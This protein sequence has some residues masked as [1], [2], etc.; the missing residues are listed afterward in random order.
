MA[1]IRTGRMSP[2]PP[3]AQVATWRRIARTD[4]VVATAIV[5]RVLLAAL[6]VGTVLGVL[7]LG[8][9]ALVL[10]KLY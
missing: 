6:A 2:P 7:F 9:L 3:P 4:P 5:L 10:F 1:P 8:A